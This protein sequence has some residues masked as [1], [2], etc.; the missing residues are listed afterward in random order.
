[1]VMRG[2]CEVRGMGQAVK[3]KL[4]PGCH[5]AGE[6][7]AVRGLGGYQHSLPWASMP[8]PRAASCAAVMLGPPQVSVPKAPALSEAEPLPHTSLGLVSLAA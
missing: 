2:S 7:R 8:R 1:M 5:G 6:V 3:V 4:E